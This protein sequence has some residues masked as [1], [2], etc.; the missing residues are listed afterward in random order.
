MADDNDDTAEFLLEEGTRTNIEAVLS[1]SA[2]Q[3]KDT[4]EKADDIFDDI[5]PEDVAKLIKGLD[6][7]DSSTDENVV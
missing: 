4:L 5:N 2:S 3:L 7:K 6:I 1:S